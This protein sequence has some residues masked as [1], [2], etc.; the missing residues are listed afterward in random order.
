MDDT[1]LTPLE[2]GPRSANLLDHLG[3]HPIQSDV[4]ATTM[5]EQVL[6]GGKA[7]PLSPSH[8]ALVHS[9]KGGGHAVPVMPGARRIARHEIL[10]RHSV[11][12]PTAIAGQHQPRDSKTIGGQVIKQIEFPLQRGN[13]T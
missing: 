7:R 9:V 3:R 6:A 8:G 11:H 4:P 10:D 13:R 2:P 5:G 1:G 12:L